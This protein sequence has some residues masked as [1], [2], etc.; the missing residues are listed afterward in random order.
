[1][2][3]ENELFDL[4]KDPGQENNIAKDYPEVLN[5]M[6]AFYENWWEEVEPAINRF[7]PVIIGSEKENPVFLN[8]DNWVNGAVN[9]QW[10]IARVT[11]PPEGGVCHLHILHEGTYRI[12]LSR[13]PFHLQRNM[14]LPGPSTAVGGTLLRTGEGV[15]VE[16]GCFSVNEGEPAIVTK[17]S[18]DAVK[19]S[20]ETY[21][22]SGDTTFQAW[23]KDKNGKN[24][25]GAY[26]VKME[27][28]F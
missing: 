12:E 18:P 19:I 1:L 24:L 16:Y 8:S 23:F 10:N 26:Y 15:P 22:K 7:V 2:V 27:R 6:R 20:Y 14:V 3:G 13:W 17:D 5:S 4:N 25:C 28:L 9:S 21:L 11:G